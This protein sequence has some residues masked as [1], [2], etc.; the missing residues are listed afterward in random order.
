M[1]LTGSTAAAALAA[2]SWL[3]LPSTGL[4]QCDDGDEVQP[5]Q[6]VGTKIENSLPVTHDNSE[7]TYFRVRDPTGQKTCA[8]DPRADFS[9]INYSSLNST[10][11]RPPNEAIRRAVIVCHGLR[12]DPQNYHAGMLI[13]LAK[14]TKSNPEISVDSVAVVAPFFPNGNDKGKAFP[15]DPNGEKQNDRYPSPALVWSNTAWA[16]GAVNQYPPHRERVSSF[17]ALDQIL[18]WYG[19]RSRFPN[20]QQIVVAGHSLGGQM[21]HRYAAVG[22]TADELGLEV[23]VTWWVGDPNSLLWLSDERPLSTSKCSDYDDYYEGLTGY[24]AFGEDRSGPMNYNLELVAGGAS[25][26]R[27]NYD[28][29]GIHYGRALRD[30]GDQSNGNCSPYTTGQDRN[31]R[32]FEFIRSFP[33]SCDDPSG[34][35]CDTIDLVDSGHDAPTMFEADAGQARL[36]T[37][38]WDGDGKRAYD[39]GYPRRTSYDS[40]YPDPAHADDPLIHEDINRYA[41]QMTYKGC[42]SDVDQAQS[43]RS[44]SQQPYTGDLNSRTYCTNR[45]AAD[46]YRIAG[47]TD[48]YC[49]CGNELSSEA[50]EVVSTSCENSCPGDPSQICGGPNRLSVFS[51]VAL[52]SG[53]SGIGDILS[54]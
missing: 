43:V 38:N 25:A 34:D 45:C 37:D 11:Q 9:L 32:F 47:V 26:V 28:S 14:A 17:H 52:T 48:Q 39:F 19:D 18:Q 7:V 33:P 5:G 51:S 35:N 20:I 27:R 22:K 15:Y 24:D 3:S 36:F 40:P 8:D 21:V 12:R 4:A 44:L 41:G 6:Y 2:L 31:E 50:A 16:G 42:F 49:Y 30:K 29:K 13:A 10:R 23:P 1:R 53:G 46:G 54:G